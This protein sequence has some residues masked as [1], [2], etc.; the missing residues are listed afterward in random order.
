[1]KTTWWTFTSNFHI[2][3][4]QLMFINHSHTWR[5][6]HID[7]LCWPIGVYV[8]IGICVNLKKWRLQCPGSIKLDKKLENWSDR[9]WYL[10]KLF[11]NLL[12]FVVVVVV[13]IPQS[14]YW[15]FFRYSFLL[16]PIIRTISWTF[17][18]IIWYYYIISLIYLYRL[19]EEQ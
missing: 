3:N 18:T 1:M 19:W 14:D 11:F 6:S 12:L 4:V 8:C 9:L 7:D 2:V 17:H 10:L 13:G 16:Y 15:I 5:I